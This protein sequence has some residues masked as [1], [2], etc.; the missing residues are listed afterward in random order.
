MIPFASSSMAVA[1]ILV[2]LAT[3]T[4]RIYGYLN[5]L[6]PTLLV[7]GVV[8]GALFMAIRWILSAFRGHGTRA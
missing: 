3:T 8:I 5:G 4:N 2:I 1:D 7:F 6:L